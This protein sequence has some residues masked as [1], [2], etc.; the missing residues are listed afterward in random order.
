[1]QLPD[2]MTGL[3]GEKLLRS[4]L[5]DVRANRH[6]IAASLIQIARP[7]LTQAGLWPENM[8]PDC[9]EPEIQLYRLLK[10]EPGD[11]YSRYNA[12]LRE[13]VSFEIAL[14]HRL[15]TS[16]SRLSKSSSCKGS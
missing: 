14:D 1:M 16:E 4:G 10:G 8:F 6:S 7:R 9:E 13:L 15:R 11:T 3:P 2:L 12:L 5:A